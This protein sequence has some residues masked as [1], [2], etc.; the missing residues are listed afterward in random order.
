MMEDEAASIS[1]AETNN[2][3]LI[4]RD[5]NKTEGDGYSTLVRIEF[6]NRVGNSTFG[7]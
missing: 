3:T 4:F 5:V 6:D 2:S 1:L 7:K